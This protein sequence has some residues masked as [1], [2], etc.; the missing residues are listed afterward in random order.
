MGIAVSSAWGWGMRPDGVGDRGGVQ[1]HACP[2]ECMHMLHFSTVDPV[3]S[4][5]ALC[6]C[7]CNSVQLLALLLM[8]V[9][10]ALPPMTQL[11]PLAVLRQS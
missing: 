3:L 11:L 2:Q 5:F 1:R 7:T 6:V 4:N 8:E 10:H 9:R